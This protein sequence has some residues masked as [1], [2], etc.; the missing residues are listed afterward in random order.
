MSSEYPDLN[1]PWLISPSLSPVYLNNPG[2]T[3]VTIQD[4]YITKV[5]L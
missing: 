3:L 4:S 5:D 1:L 2:Y